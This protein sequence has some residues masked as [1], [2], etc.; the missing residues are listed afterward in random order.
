MGTWVSFVV[1]L[2]GVERSE[3]A[4]LGADVIVMTVSALDGWTPEDTELLN[5]IVSKKVLQATSLSL[6]LS[7][8]H[9]PAR[10]HTNTILSVGGIL[11]LIWCF[12]IFPLL[13]H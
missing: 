2:T 9:V 13:M 11:V 5:R 7:Q 3:A 6:S 8:T 1:L 4:A 10:A 12:S